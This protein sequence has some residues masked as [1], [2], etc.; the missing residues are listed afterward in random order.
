MFPNLDAVAEKDVASN[1]GD[2]NP[3]ARLE[4]QA[5]NRPVGNQPFFAW[6]F[7]VPVVVKLP[8]KKPEK[9]SRENNLQNREEI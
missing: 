3:N 8:D 9:Q 2:K 7:F 4:N 1:K 6:R 5:M